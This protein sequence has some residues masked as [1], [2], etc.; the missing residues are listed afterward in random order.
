MCLHPAT[1][2]TDA[3]RDLLPDYL[4]MDFD[5]DVLV[6]ANVLM[7]VGWRDEALRLLP[8]K[9]E[10]KDVP[11]CRNRKLERMFRR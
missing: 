6:R 9:E 7:M 5:D 1:A 8:L 3:D 2:R 10:S 4:T 11:E